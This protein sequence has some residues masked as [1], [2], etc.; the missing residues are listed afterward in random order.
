MD[1]QTD[2]ATSELL[3][4][5]TPEGWTAKCVDNCL[6][7]FDP[8]G[9]TAVIKINKSESHSDNGS[10]IDGQWSQG[11]NFMVLSQMCAATF[12]RP[13]GKNILNIQP[14]VRKR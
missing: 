5:A 8:K 10:A 13:L 12:N 1:D 4:A 9:G 6:L 3:S 2:L 11:M 7:V 14:T